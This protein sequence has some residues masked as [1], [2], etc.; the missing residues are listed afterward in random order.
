[1]SCCNHNCNQGRDCPARVAKVKNRAPKHPAPL[2]EE[3]RNVYLRHL[4]KWML[5]IIA[6]LFAAAFVVGAGHA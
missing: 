4:A 2:R 5:V 6:V 3:I 1:M